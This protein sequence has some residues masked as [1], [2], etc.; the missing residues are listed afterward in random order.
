VLG[1]AAGERRM[2]G[3]RRARCIRARAAALG[4]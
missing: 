1:M 2:R 3:R 4:F